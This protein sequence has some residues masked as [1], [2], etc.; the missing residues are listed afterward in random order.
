MRLSLKYA[1]F[2]CLGVVFCNPSSFVKFSF[3]ITDNVHSNLVRSQHW[4]SKISLQDSR[5]A[6]QHYKCSC[7]FAQV[8]MIF[9]KKG[10]KQAEV[11]MTDLEKKLRKS[12]REVRMSNVRVVGVSFWAK[13]R[14]SSS[15]F[16]CLF[17]TQNQLRC[18]IKLGIFGAS[19]ATHSCQ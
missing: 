4:G 13:C 8:A 9:K 6:R 18:T 12:K 15:M 1:K 3:V 5:A 17:R 10:S 2:C 19:E 7:F 11:D 16:V 14:L